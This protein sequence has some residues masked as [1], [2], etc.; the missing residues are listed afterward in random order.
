MSLH[1]YTKPTTT[2]QRLATRSC[3]S[4]LRGL[5]LYLLGL[6]HTPPAAAPPTLEEEQN[7]IFISYRPREREST[8]SFPIRIMAVGKL[9]GKVA[10]V[11]GASTGIGRA[12]AITFAKEGAKV[13]DVLNVSERSRVRPSVEQFPRAHTLDYMIPQSRTVTCC[14]SAHRHVQRSPCLRTRSSTRREACT[15][16]RD[17]FTE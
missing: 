11:T 15:K 8:K 4:S 16:H 9:E 6:L 2:S 3:S 1:F 13:C 7:K 12:T 10:L 17:L 14:G 5:L